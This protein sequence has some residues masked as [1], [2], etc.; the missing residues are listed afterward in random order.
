MEI[1]CFIFARGGSKGIKNKN[2]KTFGGKPLIAHS[3][4]LAKGIPNVRNIFVSSDS[5]K[6]LKI[7]EQLNIQVIVRPKTLADDKSPEIDAWKHAISFVES[8]NKERDYF[9]SLPP[10]SPLRKKKYIVEAINKLKNSK[11][12]DG[13]VG[14]CASDHHPSFNMVKIQNNSINILDSSRQINRRQDFDPVYNLTTNFYLFKTSYLLKA[15][16]FLQ[17]K[18]GFVVVD[19]ESA[20][21][22]DDE[23]DFKFAELIY[24]SN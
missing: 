2:I 16:S 11:S 8:K 12:L 17:G 21:D 14:I 19:K 3:I 22:I 6:I 1:N 20:I 9:L 18:I 5:S 10:T 15:D 23:Y 4:D 24:N 13:V 7:S